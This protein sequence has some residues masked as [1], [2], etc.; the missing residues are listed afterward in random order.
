MI[1]K[2]Y[3]LQS[4]ACQ[5]VVEFLCETLRQIVDSG[6]LCIVDL[7][8]ILGKSTSLAQPLTDI[9][10][11]VSVVFTLFHNV[12]E[13]P[14]QQQ[15]N[16]ESVLLREHVDIAQQI[17]NVFAAI[18]LTKYV[19]SFFFIVSQIDQSTNVRNKAIHNGYRSFGSLP[20]LNEFC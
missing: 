3:L 13:Q 5:D 7:F 9:T 16:V 17:E 11:L 15:L 4:S 8:H 6:L 18:V 10:N 20:F 19:A 1:Q 12:G 14:N 2:E